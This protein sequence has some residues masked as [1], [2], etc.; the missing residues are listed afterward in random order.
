MLIQLMQQ[1]LYCTAAFGNQAPKWISPWTPELL[2]RRFGLDEGMMTAAPE[3]D[4]LIPTDVRAAEWR[5]RPSTASGVPLSAQGGGRDP[6]D[7]A[8]AGL[9]Q[10]AWMKKA[11]EVNNHAKARN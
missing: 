2:H 4:V 9:E 1:K 5:D 6:I 7:A 11:M 8:M 10:T 3:E